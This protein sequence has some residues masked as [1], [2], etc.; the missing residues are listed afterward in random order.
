MS[1]PTANAQ[2]LILTVGADGKFAGLVVPELAKRGAKVRGL[3]HRAEHKDTVLKSGATEVA[4]GDLTDAA[5]LKAALQGVG[6]VFYIA[7]AF[8]ENEAEVGVNMVRAAQAAGVRRFVFSSVI[9]PVISALINHSAKAPVEAALIESDMEFV[10]LQPAMFFQNFAQSWP[11]AVQSGTYAE[12][13]SAQTRF[14]HVD[15]RDVAEVA[16]IALCEDRL[17]FG[18]FELCAEGQH[19]RIEVAALMSEVLG[20][21]IASGDVDPSKMTGAPAPDGQPSP[22]QKM[23][24]WYEHHGLLGNA[25][26]LRAI[27]G[28]EP[29]TLRAYFQEL[30][31]G[32]SPR[33]TR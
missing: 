8:I 12:P 11:K 10:L 27:L 3:V 2:P 31:S 30:A 23:V 32:A 28:R 4:I 6:S 21:P 17:N 14:S 18:T 24:A 26:T 1:T 13:W 9:H 15:Y 25:L 16:A 20:K 5:S 33:A 29:R 22:I 7:P 19:N